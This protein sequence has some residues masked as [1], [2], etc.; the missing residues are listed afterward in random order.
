[1]SREQLGEWR[2]CS[3][4]T[5]PRS[6]RIITKM[7]KQS[8]AHRRRLTSCWIEVVLPYERSR[9]NSDDP[10]DDYEYSLESG[11]RPG[12]VSSSTCAF[13][14]PRMAF[15]YSVRRPADATESQSIN[16]EHLLDETIDK[17]QPLSLHSGLPRQPLQWGARMPRNTWRLQTLSSIFSSSTKRLGPRRPVPW[18]LQLQ[19]SWAR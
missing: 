1:M 10:R 11:A 12:C 8:Y 2:P 16:L 18:L 5:C 6:G 9:Q 15:L 14:R 4:V 13:F 3:C 19:I 17:P 7:R